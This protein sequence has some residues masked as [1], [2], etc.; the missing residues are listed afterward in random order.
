MTRAKDKGSRGRGSATRALERGGGQP[1]SLD[2]QLRAHG[3]LDYLTHTMYAQNTTTTVALRSTRSARAPP[4]TSRP[5]L[6]LPLLL[7]PRGLLARLQLRLDLLR[8]L[9]VDGA[10]E[11]ALG[12]DHLPLPGWSKAG[13][14]ARLWRRLARAP[15]AVAGRPVGRSRSLPWERRASQSC[16]S[17]PEEAQEPSWALPK[18]APERQRRLSSAPPSGEGP[19]LGARGQP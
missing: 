11:L 15:E 4:C 18:G 6:V 14:W 1:P 16:Q 10:A 3:P 5:L 13:K 9:A 19:P 12:L 8:G 2:S 17:R 7:H